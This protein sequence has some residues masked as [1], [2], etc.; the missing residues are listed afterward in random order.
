MITGDLAPYEQTVIQMRA[1]GITYAKIHE[2]ICKNG[3]SGTISSFRVFMQKE[4]THRRTV[5]S[6]TSEPVEYIPR[7]YMI[8]FIYRDLKKIKH[9]TTEQYQAAIYKY[10]ELDQLY[11]VLKEFHRIVFSR[12]SS[13]LEQW[14]KVAP[15]CKLKS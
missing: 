2:Y 15:L 7:K 5:S 8:Q 14:T 10:P 9:I 13:E 4:R 1:Q 3:Y 11:T 12:K 6:K